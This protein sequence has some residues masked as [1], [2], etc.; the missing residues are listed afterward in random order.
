MSKNISSDTIVITAE[1]P[2]SDAATLLMKNLSAELAQ[3]YD[4]D[5]SGW[6]SPDD[7]LA[8]GGAM[9]VA[10]LNGETVG[11]GAI[12]RI[13]EHVAEVKRMYVEP[14]ARGRGIGRMILQ[15]LE[16]VARKMG[17]SHARL[18][19]GNRQP[20]AI[21]MYEASGYERINCYGQYADNPLSLCFEKG[22]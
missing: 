15:E 20:E 12:R 1:D 10:R 17:Y 18:E 8:G 21:K 16:A 7:V 2:R 11:C 5:G 13:A 3:K 22:L 19:T 9:L 6:F 14:R 4:D